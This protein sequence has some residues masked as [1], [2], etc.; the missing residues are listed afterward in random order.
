MGEELMQEALGQKPKKLLLARRQLSE[1]EMKQLLKKDSEK[2]ASDEKGRAQ[3]GGQKKIF[4]DE[5]GEQVEASNEDL[6]YQGSKDAPIKGLG[7][8]SHR[9]A[10]L[11]AIKAATMGTKGELEGTSASSFMKKEEIKTE[12][13]SEI[14]SEAFM[15]QESFTLGA[16][17]EKQEEVKQEGGAEV[18]DEDDFPREA[19]GK[20]P[21]E[22]INDAKDRG[23]LEK[24]EERKRK[25]A[26]KKLKKMA[27]KEKKAL[28]R[29]KKAEKAAK[30]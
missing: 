21:R 14:K 20:R 3:M 11:E 7:F 24:K 19:K 10:R 12:V 5:Q 1:Q 4:T 23:K 27:K 17:R 18:K 26:E 22:E 30:K 29:E 28:K 2:T 6:V 9:T 13:K 15:D 16:K 25:K 8:A